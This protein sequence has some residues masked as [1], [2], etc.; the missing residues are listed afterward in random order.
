M[1]SIVLE[2]LEDFKGYREAWEGLHHEYGAQIFSSYDLVHLW[3][4]NFKAEVKPYIVLIEDRGELIG[5][6]PM[7]TSHNRVMGLPVNSLTMVG[8]MYPLF[9]YGLYS[10]FA[11]RDDPEAIGEMLNCV[12][13]AKWNKLIMSH[14]DT[15]ISTMKF[16]NGIMHMWEGRSSV[17]DPSI[18]HYYVYPKEGN[19]TA[20][21]GKNTRAN[22]QR[23]RNKLEKAGR[24]DFHKVE[25]VEDAERAM[26]LYLLHH[27]ERW[28]NKNTILR[29]QTNRKMMMDLAKLAVS[30]GKGEINELLIDGEVAGQLFDL[31]DGD[32]SRGVRVGMMDKFQE[33][34]PGL[35]VLTLTM[36]DNRKMGFKVYDPG[37]GNEGYKLRIS[38][39]HRA[40]GSALVYKGIM[41][42]V[43]RVRSLH[44]VKVPENRVMPK[45]A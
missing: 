36:E 6:A 8:D 27:E 7:C 37:Y 3:L 35:L 10:V 23:A 34:S 45:D 25:S 30:S 29:S 33:F 28:E 9:G 1:R 43:S 40:L 18:N 17:L 41:G 12:K 24:M 22:I 5:A 15:N 38:N 39:N 21:F 13:R 14:M 42:V 19:I 31:F 32:I 11:K 16:L 4:D 26:N 20:N 44:S 2:S